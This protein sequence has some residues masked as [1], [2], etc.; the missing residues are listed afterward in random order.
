[1]Y[2]NNYD[3]DGSGGLDFNE[4]ETMIM[5]GSDGHDHGGNG[6]EHDDGHGYGHDEYESNLPTDE[7]EFIYLPIMTDLVA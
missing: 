5:E 6:D 7:M 3:T 1:M 2:F 4:F